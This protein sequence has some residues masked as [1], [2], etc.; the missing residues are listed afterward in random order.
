MAEEPKPADSGLL[1]NPATVT[2]IMTAHLVAN[3]AIVTTIQEE[4]KQ[5]QNDTAFI[6]INAC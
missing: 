2:A 3:L 4:I 1:P 5:R 6:I